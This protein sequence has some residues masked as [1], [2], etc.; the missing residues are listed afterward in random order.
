MSHHTAL[1][2]KHFEGI[3]PSGHMQGRITNSSSLWQSVR[4]PSTVSV[5]IV[6]FL[7]QHHERQLT[8]NPSRM[9]FGISFNIRNMILYIA[10]THLPCLYS[11]SITHLIHQH[12]Y[13]Y[14][15][16]YIYSILLSSIAVSL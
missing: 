8:A 12:I 9:I 13:I 11:I 15:Y 3:V 2:R 5:A 6:G 7:C 10:R 14:I 1:R 4:R 16:I